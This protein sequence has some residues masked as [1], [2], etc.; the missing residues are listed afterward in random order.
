MKGEYNVQETQVSK[1][2]QEARQ[3]PKR[4]SQVSNACKDG[5]SK[6]P[7][8]LGRVA[9]LQSK[10]KFQFG[11]KVHDTYWPYILGVV[12]KVLKTRRHV[13]FYG[14]NRA[15]IYDKAHYKFLVKE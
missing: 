5:T 12:T 10:M 1:I 15:A 11:D 7:R 6:V 8:N 3:G 13:M 4:M 2:D 14:E 9:K